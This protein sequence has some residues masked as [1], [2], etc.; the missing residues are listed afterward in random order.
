MVG[1]WVQ[2]ITVFSSIRSNFGYGRCPKNGLNLKE[3]SLNHQTSKQTLPDPSST[4]PENLNQIQAI[5][6]WPH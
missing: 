6:D 1:V 5:F 3:H 4:L 2:K